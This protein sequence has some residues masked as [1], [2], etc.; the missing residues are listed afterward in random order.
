MLADHTVSYGALLIGIDR[1]S[2][3]IGA[4][5]RDRIDT[6]IIEMVHRLRLSLPD[7]GV[8]GRLD[9]DRFIMLV[10]NPLHPDYYDELARTLLDRLRE[11]IKIGDFGLTIKTAIGIAGHTAN[12]SDQDLIDC[13]NAALSAARATGGDCYLFHSPLLGRDVRDRLEREDRLRKAIDGGQ[14]VLHYQPKFSCLNGQ[15]TGCEALVRCRGEDGSIIPPGAFIALAE[16]SGLIYRITDWVV[17]EAAR[18]AMEWQGLGLPHCR[19]AVN[20]SPVLF[21]RR[22][23]EKVI[24]ELFQATGV[25]PGTLEV[26]ITEGVITQD[27]TRATQLLNELRKLGVLVAMD[28]FGT[29]YS[30]LSLLKRLP[31]DYL[32]IDRCFVTDLENDPNDRAIVD[33]IIRLAHSLQ[34]KVIAEGVEEPS[35]V[36]LLCQAGC[37]YLQGYHLSYPVEAEV[38][39]RLL[40]SRQC[41]P[42]GQKRPNT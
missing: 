18:Q 31:I 10:R 34:M 5:G 9:D 33:T 20:L 17:N 22:D 12:H 42:I 24:T 35:Q 15:L 39:E 30:S 28:D 26:E 2:H 29:G 40:E 21:E 11:P 4:L 8:V 37:D 7:E 1:H 38:M 16:E 36:N 32:K 41:Y 6:L 3:L 27:E 13:A 14:L 23:G 25:P 19:V